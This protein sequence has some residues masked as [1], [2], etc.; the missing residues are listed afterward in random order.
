MGPAIAASAR[1]LVVASAVLVA[2]CSP[3]ASD[4]VNATGSTPP[5]TAAGSAASD[6]V[7]AVFRVMAEACGTGVE[8]LATGVALTGRHIVTV[9]H[10]FDDAAAVEVAGSDGIRHPVDVVWLDAE[11]DLAVLRV[12]GPIVPWLAL[13][14]A[15]RGEAVTVLSAG[16]DGIETKPAAVLRLVDVSLDGVGKRAGLELEVEVGLGDSGSPVVAESGAVVGVVFASDR[17]DSRGWAIA[18]TE[19]EAALRRSESGPVPLSC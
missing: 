13:A 16:E 5:P 3:P 7:D 6:P 4:G 11:R 18:A 10:T 8:G 2:A 15:E 14:E 17:N 12:S 1:L 19:L 9:A